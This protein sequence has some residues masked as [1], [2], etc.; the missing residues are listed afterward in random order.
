M[1]WKSISVPV[2]H[3]VVSLSEK[4]RVAHRETTFLFLTLKYRVIIS[5]FNVSCLM[6]HVFIPPKTPLEWNHRLSSSHEITRVISWFQLYRVAFLL[7]PRQNGDGYAFFSSTIFAANACFLIENCCFC[8]VF[9]GFWGGKLRR[10][11]PFRG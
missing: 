10:L 6:F 7:F 3:F 11:V 9:D 8:M 4:R 1:V 5:M 2:L